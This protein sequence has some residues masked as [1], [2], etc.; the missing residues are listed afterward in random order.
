MQ[1][2]KCMSTIK[3]GESKELND[4]IVQ[5]ALERQKRIERA[6]IAEEDLR[7]R[8][9]GLIKQALSEPTNNQN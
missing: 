7:E 1:E 4:K 2:V 3:I 6:K 5:E 9:P 8:L